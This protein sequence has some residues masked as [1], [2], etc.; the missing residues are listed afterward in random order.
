MK[1]AFDI[2]GVAIDA[3]DQAVKKAYLEQVRSSPPEKSPDKFREIQDAYGHLKTER[4]RAAYRL[5][6]MPVAPEAMQGNSKE[7]RNS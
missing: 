5:F 7:T 4:A 6:H 2:L 3:D 1:T